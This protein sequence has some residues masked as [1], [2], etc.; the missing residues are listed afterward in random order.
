LVAAKA[1]TRRVANGGM[2]AKI[3]CLWFTAFM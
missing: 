2:V 3:I 1:F